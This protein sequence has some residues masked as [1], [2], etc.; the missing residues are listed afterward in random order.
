M[1]SGDAPAYDCHLEPRL[2]NRFTAG[3]EYRAALRTA[4]I[5]SHETLTEVTV[6]VPP[7]QRFVVAAV[8]DN[9]MVGTFFGPVW[10]IRVLEKTRGKSALHAVYLEARDQFTKD[11][12]PFGS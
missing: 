3:P 10:E 5:K 1:G 6:L 4:R 2:A 9:T 8:L 7:S 11:P 12:T